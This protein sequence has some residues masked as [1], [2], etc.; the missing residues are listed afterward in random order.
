MNWPNCDKCDM[1]V[2]IQEGAIAVSTREAEEAEE[3]MRAWD[4]SHRDMLV[5]I[6]EFLSRPSPA[7][8]QWGHQAYIPE[9][10]DYAVDA[11]HFDSPGKALSVTLHLMEKVWV[12]YT[13]W[14]NFVRRIHR[15]SLSNGEGIG[16]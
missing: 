9:N 11:A 13:D 15:E 4:Q 3:A 6:D 8:W 12:P 16:G 10:N 1:V 14:I 2:Q 5:N 7:K